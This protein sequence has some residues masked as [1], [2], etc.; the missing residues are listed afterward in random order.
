MNIFNYLILYILII[1]E[2]IIRGTQEC[3]ICRKYNVDLKNPNWNAWFKNECDNKKK[4][5]DDIEK[6]K[7]CFHYDRLLDIHQENFWEIWLRCN[8]EEKS[9]NS[10]REEL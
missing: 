8:C 1:Y 3:E 5:M 7:I 10:F 2:N 6:R 4:R 9:L